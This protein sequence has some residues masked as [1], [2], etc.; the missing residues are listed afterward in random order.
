MPVSAP[1]FP[2]TKPAASDYVSDPFGPGK[3]YQKQ[4]GS[5]VRNLRYPPCCVTILCYAI[6]QE[7]FL[8]YHYSNIP[9][10]N[11]LIAP[12]E[13]FVLALCQALPAI[14]LLFAYR[15]RSHLM[16]LFLYYLG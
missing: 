11:S 14:F 3:I 10:Y 6:R 7:M 12:E 16:N 8:S 1:T 13:V 2:N 5:F 9:Y 4:P 15:K